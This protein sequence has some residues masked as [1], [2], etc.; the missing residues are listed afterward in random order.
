MRIIR[1][2]NTN[3]YTVKFLV[4]IYSH[5]I[6]LYSESPYFIGLYDVES[7]KTHAAPVP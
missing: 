6:E 3:S 1:H 5:P 4:S 7:T 2:K